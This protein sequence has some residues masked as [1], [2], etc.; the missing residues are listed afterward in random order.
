MVHDDNTSTLC[1]PVVI[2]SASYS[3]PG[4]AGVGRDTLDCSSKLDEH[5]RSSSSSAKKG[6]RCVG[7]AGGAGNLGFCGEFEYKYRAT[8]NGTRNAPPDIAVFGTHDRG[9]MGDY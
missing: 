6:A 3:R 5:R 9:W 7:S 8:Q 4:S 1:D 2:C